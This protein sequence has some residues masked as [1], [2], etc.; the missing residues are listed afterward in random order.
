MQEKC[1]FN[2]YELFRNCAIST[3][4]RSW[5]DIIKQN[6]NN[7]DDSLSFNHHI[8]RDSRILTVDKLTSRYL[9]SYLILNK[10]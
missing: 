6:K 3:I 10:I 7:A 5:K 2:G 9:Y 1:T 4:S 8:I